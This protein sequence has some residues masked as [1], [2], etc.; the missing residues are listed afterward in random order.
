MR[1]R[2]IFNINKFITYFQLYFYI[3]HLICTLATFKDYYFIVILF[4]QAKIFL[5]MHRVLEFHRNLFRNL[6]ILCC[7]SSLNSGEDR[8]KLFGNFFKK[9][10]YCEV[11]KYMADRYKQNLKISSSCCRANGF[12]T[13][14]SGCRPRAISGGY[15]IKLKQI[16][17][18]LI[19]L[20][21]RILCY[22]GN[23]YIDLDADAAENIKGRPLCLS[24][25][26][27][28]LCKIKF[29]NKTKENG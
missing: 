5:L 9:K 2:I 22:P 25:C 3:F 16:F 14:L 21:G 10:Q 18:P 8:R 7:L 19:R 11:L 12:R 13:E 1:E 17:R 15:H 28:G 24:I 27:N 26:H 6:S 29:Q 4:Q 23:T 20:S